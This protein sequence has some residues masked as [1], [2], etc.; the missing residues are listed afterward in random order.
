MSGIHI[1]NGKLRL[2]VLLYTAIQHMC[3]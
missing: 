1:D 2:A 3:R